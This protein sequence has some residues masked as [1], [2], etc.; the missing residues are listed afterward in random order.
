MIKTKE[1]KLIELTFENIDKAYEIDR[2]DIPYDYVEDVQTLA[3]I[4]KYGADNNLIGHAY[5][6]E[7]GGKPIG[8]IMLGEGIVGDADPAELQNRPFYRLMFFVL[9]KDYRGNGLGTEMMEEAISRIYSEFGKRPILLE[10]QQNNEKAAR[11]Y[12]KNGFMKTTYSVGNDNY[13]VRG[14]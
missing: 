14:L 5:L 3:D 2:T 8:T 1:L 12:E 11:F 10:V 13:F 9:D 6:A 4:M 7:Y